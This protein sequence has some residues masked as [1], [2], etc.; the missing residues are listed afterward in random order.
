M[1]EECKTTKQQILILIKAR[2]SE[3][4]SPLEA[5]TLKLKKSESR[6]GRNKEGESSGDEVIKYLLIELFVVEILCHLL[7]LLLFQGL[8]GGCLG[9]LD[10]FL[11]FLLFHPIK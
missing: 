2:G 8:L 7:N 9:R 4:T 5:M 6:G 3:A 1:Y 10:P 11:F